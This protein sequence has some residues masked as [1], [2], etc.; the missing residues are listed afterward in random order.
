MKLARRGFAIASLAWHAVGAV[1]LAGVLSAASAQTPTRTFDHLKTGFA[2][3]GTHIGQ[4][5]EACHQMGVFKGTPLDCASCHTAGFRLASANVV[6]P[7]KHIPTQLGCGFC[8]N[9]RV[10]SGAKFNHLGVPA[11]GCSSVYLTFTSFSRSRTSARSPPV[12]KLV[13][14]PLASRR[15]VRPMRCT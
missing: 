4:R 2:L 15:A 6:K 11:G 1:L 7:D 14:L 10:F 12:T 9:T 13:A 3:T 8:H 5:C